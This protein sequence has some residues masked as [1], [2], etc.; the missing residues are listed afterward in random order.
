[1][2]IAGRFVNG[3]SV[4]SALLKYQS[5]SLSWRHRAI[6]VGWWG[7]NNV[8][9]YVAQLSD[10]LTMYR[11]DHLGYSYHVL[12]FVWV[13]VVEGPTDFRVPWGL[14]MIPAVFLFGAMIFLPESPRWLARNNRWDE[15]LDVLALVHGKGNKESPL[16]TK[17]MSEI[18]ESVEFERNNADVTYF[19][20]LKPKMINRTHIGVFTQIWSQLT[21]MNVMMCKS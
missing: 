19:E 7:V 9:R 16:V 21:G 3:F 5:I 18:K 17:E 10:G 14:Q 4:E 15:T 2:L 20:L 1:M 8:S 6:V 12:H 11:G 13:F